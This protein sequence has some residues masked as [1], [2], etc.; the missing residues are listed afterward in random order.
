LGDPIDTSTPQGVFTLQILGAVAELERQLIRSCRA[1]PAEKETEAARVL[2]PS[3]AL[4]SLIDQQELALPGSIPAW[5]T[6]PKRFA[7]INPLRCQILL[8][9]VQPKSPRLAFLPLCIGHHGTMRP[10]PGQAYR[11]RLGRPTLGTRAC[12]TSAAETRRRDAAA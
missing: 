6:I 2:P 9:L 4:A 7:R 8:M 1:R 3:P 11:F 12:R 5:K 10:Q